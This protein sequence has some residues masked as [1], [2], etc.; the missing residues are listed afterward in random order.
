MSNL[1]IAV[2]FFDSRAK[3]RKGC[4]FLSLFMKTKKEKSSGKWE[5]E[6]ETEWR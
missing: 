6:E 2:L 4:V 1:L 3:N 5:G